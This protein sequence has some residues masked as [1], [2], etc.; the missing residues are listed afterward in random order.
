MILNTSMGNAVP[1]VKP[2]AVAVL[3]TN[4]VHACLAIPLTPNMRTVL[5]VLL[6]LTVSMLAARSAVIRLS[7]RVLFV[8]SAIVEE[9]FL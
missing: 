4:A 8:R 5:L 9:I 7:R 1:P 3:K 6:P 2:T